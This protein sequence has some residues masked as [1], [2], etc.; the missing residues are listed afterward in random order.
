MSYIDKQISSK[1]L[2]SEEEESNLDKEKNAMA[3]KKA[4]YFNS[5]DEMCFESEL[6]DSPVKRK[7]SF[8]K[9]VLKSTEDERNKMRDILKKEKKR[10]IQRF[11][12]D[13]NE[14][15][16]HFLNAKHFKEDD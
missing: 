6:S 10:N 2:F 3:K 9:V 4:I 11:L 13:I 14:T 5:N 7:H 1:S 8:T 16:K 15:K 12:N